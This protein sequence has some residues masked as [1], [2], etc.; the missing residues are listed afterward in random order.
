MKVDASEYAPAGKEACNPDLFYSENRLHDDGCFKQDR[1][2]QSTS[3]G[4]YLTSGRVRN[5]NCGED[6]AELAACHPNLRFRN[7][8]GPAA[9][10]AIDEDSQLRYGQKYTNPRHRQQLQSR[11]YH[12]H[13]HYERGCLQPDEESSLIHTEGTRT[14][15]PCG[16]LSGVEIDRFVPLIPCIES[17]V[18]D[19]Q[20]VVND[21]SGT[22]TRAWVRDEDYIQRCG[23]VHDGR[24]W[25]R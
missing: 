14:S 23:F 22:N 10:C 19:P 25:R 24:G 3:V 4:D 12:G 21:R 17:A 18:Q 9:A 6:V 16:V 20:H 15:R 11:V 7:G 8:Y 2:R 1:D 13:P 5:G